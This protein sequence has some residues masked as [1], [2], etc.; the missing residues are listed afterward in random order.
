MVSLF[1]EGNIFDSY[2]FDEEE[3]GFYGSTSIVRKA[4]KI[5]DGEF[6]AVKI[7]DSKEINREIISNEINIIQ[8]M[9]HPNIVK[10]LEY[11]IFEQYFMIVFEWMAGGELFDRISLHKNYTER[12]ACD[13]FRK[14]VDG[15]RY[16]H[17]FNI[18][19]RDLKPENILYKTADS[20]EVKISD[21]GL[22]KYFIGEKMYSAVGT[23]YY[24]APEILLSRGYNEKCDI[25]SLGVLLY[26]MIAGYP[27]FD[28][29]D[30]NKQERLNESILLGVFTFPEREW[31]QVS[32]EC[33]SLIKDMLKSNPVERPSAESVLE[34][35]W[36]EMFLYGDNNG[37]NL[38]F[39][40]TTYKNY[41][42][43][44]L[45]SNTSLYYKR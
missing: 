2:V 16:C 30:P 41:N 34:Y 38:G 22:A 29:D 26:V 45:T 6:Y 23:P 3:E 13:L 42:K 36:F 19:H 5:S 40:N 1:K 44:R 37:C 31:S 21:F 18:V 43:R 9:T 14:I 27:P 25:W 12:V 33:K 28:T 7:I 11:Y 24:I 35:N 17:K 15:V 10:V 20:T 4:I 8:S 32:K 39:N